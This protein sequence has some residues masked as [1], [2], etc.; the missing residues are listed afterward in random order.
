VGLQLFTALG[1]SIVGEIV[2]AGERVFLDLK[3][4]DIP[5]TAAHAVA[6]ASR[7]GASFT[8]VHVAGGEAMLRA[9]AE[10]AAPRTMVLGVTLL[11]SLDA[12]AA[13]EVGFRGEVSDIVARLALLAKRCGLHGVVAS[14]HEVAGIKR[15]CGS[16]F[17]TV[18]PGIRPAGAGVQDQRRAATPSEAIR[19]GADYL[20]VGRPITDAPDPVGAAEAIVAEIGG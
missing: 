1:P 10:A 18:V 20:V 8:D 6:E 5:N 16:S 3:Y 19:N 11:T 14:A 2:A 13:R 4:H 17:L 7:L 9:A 15:A 12:A